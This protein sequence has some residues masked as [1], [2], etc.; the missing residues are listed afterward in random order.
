MMGLLITLPANDAALLRNH[1]SG[2]ANIGG[3]WPP[4]SGIIINRS[5]PCTETASL[6]AVTLKTR[7]EDAVCMRRPTV[8]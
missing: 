4:S 2:N 3:R 6:L 1:S 8:A 5:S 7:T